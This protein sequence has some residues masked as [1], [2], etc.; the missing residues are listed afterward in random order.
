[1]WLHPEGC[2]A[3]RAVEAILEKPRREAAGVE[4]M[5]ASAQDKNFVFERSLAIFCVETTKCEGRP[6]TMIIVVCEE[7]WAMVGVK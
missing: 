6:T 3:Q 7:A 2:P 4:A 5:P 1:M